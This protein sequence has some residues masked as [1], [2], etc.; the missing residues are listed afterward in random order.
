[1]GEFSQTDY[2][3]GSWSVFGQEFRLPGVPVP[4]MNVEPRV[5][6]AGQNFKVWELIFFIVDL[7]LG[8]S[9]FPSFLETRL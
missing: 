4:T 5:I 1:M 3:Y 9:K 6:Q 2:S 7:E 8:N